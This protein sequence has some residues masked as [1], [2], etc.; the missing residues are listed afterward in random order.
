MTFRSGYWLQNP[1]AMERPAQI[2]F[3]KPL[4]LYEKSELW[5]ALLQTINYL[6][7]RLNLFFLPFLLITCQVW[8]GLVWVCFGFFFSVWVCVLVLFWTE[9]YFTSWTCSDSS[10]TV[11]WLTELKGN[12][13]QAWTK[14]TTY[15][16][17]LHFKTYPIRSLSSTLSSAPYFPWNCML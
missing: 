7:S 16:E 9:C 6:L 11:G 13:S 2:F 14:S 8:S 12:L 15:M 3:Q 4:W 17:M 10:V 5:V 1:E